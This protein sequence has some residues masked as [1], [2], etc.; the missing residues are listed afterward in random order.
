MR[1]SCEGVE[2]ST[3]SIPAGTSSGWRVIAAKRRPDLGSERRERAQQVQDIGL[4]A[5]AAAAEHVGVD[6]D[7]LH[8]ISFH[9]A[10]VASATPSQV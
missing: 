3:G 4:V 1:S 10:T 5:G 9:A 8:A 7:Q 6:R 2:S